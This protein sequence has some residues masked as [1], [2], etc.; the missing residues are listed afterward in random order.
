MNKNKT[1]TYTNN[2]IPQEHKQAAKT[3]RVKCLQ[4]KD[5]QNEYERYKDGDTLNFRNK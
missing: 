2:K 1:S 4:Y 3:D 5:M